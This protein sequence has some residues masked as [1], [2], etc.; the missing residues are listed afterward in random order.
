MAGQ[1][2][3]QSAPSST[4]NALLL[5][6]GSKRRNVAIVI[7]G[8]VLLA[9][10]AFAYFKYFARDSAPL[11]AKEAIT[12]IAV[13]PFVNASNN[14]D[15]EYLSDG[16]SESLIN[17]LSQ[18][19]ALKVIARSSSFKFKGKSAELGEVA[20]ALG[21]R[22]IVT[23]RV[24]QLGDQ[25]QISAELV[26]TADSTQVWG[27]QYNRKAIDLLAIQAEI[28][29][30]IAERLRLKLS[31]TEQQQLAKRETTNPAAYELVLKGRFFSGKGGEAGRAK[32]IEYFTQATAVDPNYALA[33]AEL[34]NA[35]NVLIASA[36]VDPKI[37]RPKA[38]AALEK[39][40]QLDETI[41]EAHVAIGVLKF[42]NWDG[43]RRSASTY[44]PLN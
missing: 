1:T 16:I 13:L 26:D 19:P 12:S 8:L 42:N 20:Q 43:R 40:L 14:P 6:S 18:L 39:A 44:A 30:E 21:V 9:V 31:S 38:Q 5:S 33:Y 23:G 41:P 7:A 28:S 35:Y 36:T 2:I 34:A 11:S 37:I 24:I 25:L 3:S 10:A 15:A 27:G 22:A 4:S 17:N 29:R 32:A